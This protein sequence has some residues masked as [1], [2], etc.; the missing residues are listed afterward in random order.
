MRLTLKD[1]QEALPRGWEVYTY[2]PGDG[3]TR[4]RFFHK[5]PKKQTYFGP[6]SGVFTAL[7]IKEAVAY[8]YGLKR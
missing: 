3:V 1:L 5:P 4:Y 8:A 2:S 6:D 7:G